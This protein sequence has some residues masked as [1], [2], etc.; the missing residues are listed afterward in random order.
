SQSEPDGR[1]SRL[2]LVAAH[3]STL[4]Q[5]RLSRLRIGLPTILIAILGGGGVLIYC[6]ILFGP[7][8]WLIHDMATIP[9]EQGML[10]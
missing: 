7:L 4:A 1:N 3:A 10:P 9:I 5:H 8:I 6:L 2:S